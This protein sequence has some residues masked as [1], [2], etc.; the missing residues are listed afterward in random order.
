M[1]KCN[2]CNKSFK[3]LCDLSKHINKFHNGIEEYYDK[4]VKKE[5]EGYC[6]ICGDKAKFNTLG[7]GY[8][9]I[10]E[11]N[12]C[13]NKFKYNNL[14]NGMI[15]KYGKHASSQI[16]ELKEK[17]QQTNIQKYGSISPLGSKKIRN[18]IERTNLNKYGTK[19]VSSNASIKKKKEETNLIK[20]GVKNVFS[21]DIIKNNI[22][23]TMLKR[24][25]VDSYLKLE[26]VKKQ[27]IFN[28]YGVYYAQQNNDIHIKQQI[29]SCKVKK[30]KNVYYRG[31]YELD[32]LEKYY[33]KYSII[34][35]PSI[36]YKYKSKNRIYHSDFLIEDL[37][38]IV[39]IKNSYLAFRD[40]KI[41][42]KKEKASKVLGF[43][44][45]MI[46]DKDYTQFE[47]MRT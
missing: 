30:Y 45:I 13:K 3:R 9:N 11:K 19:N 23:N 31:S 38:L 41:L 42:S 16:K 12:D 28:K 6:K 25:G 35:G 43:N 1:Y 47:K 29:S 22:K 27:N 18:K 32:F 20:Y 2:E 40:K 21:N 5:K 10:C 44:F 17:Q 4:W 26:D 46:I 15:K 33:D 8:F 34:N 39:E 7:K 24:Y 37:N 14:H 36:Q